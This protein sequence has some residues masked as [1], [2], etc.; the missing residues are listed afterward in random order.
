M[1]LKLFAKIHI[2]QNSDPNSFIICRLPKG[3]IN[4]N[5]QFFLQ[6]IP[7]PKFSTKK[8]LISDI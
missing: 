4:I 1:T 7:E 5:E 8:K 3:L 2:T 6:K